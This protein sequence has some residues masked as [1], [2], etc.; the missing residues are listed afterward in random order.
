MRWRPRSRSMNKVIKDDLFF[1]MFSDQQRNWRQQGHGHSSGRRGGYDN[2]S[3]RNNS[4]RQDRRRHNNHHNDIF[5]PNTPEHRE[6]AATNAVLAMYIYS[7]VVYVPNVRV[8]R[9]TSMWT[10]CVRI[11]I[12]ARIW[13]QR[14]TYPLRFCA[15]FQT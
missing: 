7:H 9:V 10:I 11:C 6:M 3:N 15:I 14:V 1:V 8:V 12:F 5:V 2:R 4:S 13:T